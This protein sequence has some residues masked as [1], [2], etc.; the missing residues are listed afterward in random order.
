MDHI[1][2]E[3]DGVEIFPDKKNIFCPYYGIKTH[4]SEAI[5]CRIIN[6]IISKQLSTCWEGWNTL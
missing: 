2:G 3:S 4:A 5:K 6:F 1:L